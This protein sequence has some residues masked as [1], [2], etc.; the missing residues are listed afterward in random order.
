MI[1]AHVRAD[2]VVREAAAAAMRKGRNMSDIVPV[3]LTLRSSISL[4]SITNVGLKRKKM[5]EKVAKNVNL[6]EIWHRAHLFV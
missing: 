2:G 3:R 6:S 4:V 1:V 5:C